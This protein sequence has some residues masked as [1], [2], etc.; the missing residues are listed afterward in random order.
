MAVLLGGRAAEA[1]VF[2]EI[3][4]GA[5]DDLDKATDIARNMVTRFGMVEKLG[6]MTYEEQPQAF[7]GEAALVGAR[8]RNYSEETAREI[9]CAIREL[10]DRAREKATQITKTRFPGW[11]RK[12]KK[13]KQK[14]LVDNKFGA[15]EL[16]Q[17]G[18]CGAAV[19]SVA[20]IATL[21]PGDKSC[22]SE[23]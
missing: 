16:G 10:T 22:P 8:R 7:L 17:E 3:S 6:Q 12:K 18:A 4:T 1:I 14:R 9:D 23:A 21:E 2:G 11:N 20:H 13:R 15:H 19:P 5:A